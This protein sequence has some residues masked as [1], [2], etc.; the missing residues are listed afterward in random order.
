MLTRRRLPWD[1]PDAIEAKQ[2]EFGTEPEIA[3]GRLSNC[4]DDAFEEAVADLPRCVRVLTDVE[5]WV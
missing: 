1:D 4:V 5:R 2:A 3:I